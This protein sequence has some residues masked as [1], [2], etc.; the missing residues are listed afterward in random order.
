MPRA[1][2]LDL[3][4]RLFRARDAGLSAAEVERTLGVSQRTQRRWAQRVAAGGD[5]TPGRPPGRVRTIAA[6]EEDDLRAQVA[7]H[8]DA[9]LAMHCAAWATAGK[10]AV[11]TATMSRTLARLKL[12]LKKRR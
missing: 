10:A 6:A 2:S 7:A 9:T 12:P 8:P 3:R 4:E 5:L 1:Y 11:S